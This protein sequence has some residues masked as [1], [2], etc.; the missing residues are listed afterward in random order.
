MPECPE[1]FQELHAAINDRPV[2]VDKPRRGRETL[3]LDQW[4]SKFIDL[5]RRHLL[6]HAYDRK[7]LVLL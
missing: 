3:Y 7:T 4:F 5:S 2:H 6:N 1:Q